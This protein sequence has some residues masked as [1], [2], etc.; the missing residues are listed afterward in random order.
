MDNFT[1]HTKQVFNNKYDYEKILKVIERIKSRCLK[2]KI[3]ESFENHPANAFDSMSLPIDENE[4]YLHDDFFLLF[5]SADNLLELN[6]SITGEYGWGGIADIVETHTGVGM[7]DWHWTLNT[8]R[9]KPEYAQVLIDSLNCFE[10]GI[11]AN[12]EKFLIEEK[13]KEDE[14][15]A[16]R[17]SIVSICTSEK[18][19]TD[20]GGK[21]KEYTHTITFHDG[22]KL[23]FSERNVFDFGI[24]INPSYGVIP[25]V[26]PG[27]LCLNRDSCLQ[28]HEFVDNKGWIPVRP[29]TE[30]EKTAMNYLQTFGKFSRHRIRM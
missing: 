29:L 1:F 20:E 12:Y 5:D 13:K 23:T 3:Y 19:I 24:V 28:W 15:E 9:L 25:G 27:G 14:R 2:H 6:K 22:E 30:N 8:Y 26:E 7:N 11:R 21:T 16:I 10:K 18:T 4:E 17:N